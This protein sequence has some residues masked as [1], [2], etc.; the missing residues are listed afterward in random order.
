MPRRPASAGARRFASCCV[1]RAPD[2]PAPAVLVS[3]RRRWRLAQGHLRPVGPPRGGGRV[4]GGVDRLGAEEVG[5]GRQRLRQ[6]G[7]QLPF[8]RRVAGHEARL[9]VGPRVCSQAPVAELSSD[10]SRV[11]VVEVGADRVR[12]AP[13]R[14]GG[15]EGDAGRNVVEAERHLDRGRRRVVAR[16]VAQ[17][18]MEDVFTRNRDRAVRNGRDVAPA[19]E[20]HA[21]VVAGALVTRQKA[22]QIGLATPWSGLLQVTSKSL[23]RRH[24]SPPASTGRTRVGRGVVVD[25]D[26]ALRQAADVAG[27]IGQAV[28]EL[29]RPVAEAV[30]GDRLR[31]GDGRVAGTHRRRTPLAADHRLRAGVLGDRNAGAVDIR[32]AEADPG[33]DVRAPGLQALGPAHTIRSR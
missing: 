12:E 25:P 16:F 32:L 9:Q 26:R 31:G 19:G 30:G 10:R 33:P 23:T 1:R 11:L 22:P 15:R 28:D 3:A 24:P 17:P 7:R 21:A 5:P 20:L 14:V 4:P 8:A 2:S 27:E 13:T 18:E 6:A 29:V